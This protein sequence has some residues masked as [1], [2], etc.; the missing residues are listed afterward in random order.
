MESSTITSISILLL[1]LFSHCIAFLSFSILPIA[2]LSVTHQYLPPIL[3]FLKTPQ[4]FALKMCSHKLTVF[5]HLFS[6][7]LSF[8]PFQLITL[9]YKLLTTLFIFFLIFSSTMLL[10]ILIISPF[11]SLFLA[12]L[13]HKTHFPF[14]SLSVNS[15]S[16]SCEI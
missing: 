3:K 14:H 16:L 1:K 6:Q 13:L 2:P 12:H 8:H 11:P 7:P 5:I 9:L 10:V 15:T 4:H